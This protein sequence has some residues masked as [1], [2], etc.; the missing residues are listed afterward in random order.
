[1]IDHVLKA[2]AELEWPLVVV[3]A[4]L[5]FRRQIS[6]LIQ[7][8]S[9]VRLG[10]QEFRVSRQIEGVEVLLE[11]NFT[12][13]PQVSL[14]PG[15]IESRIRKLLEKRPEEALRQVTVELRQSVFVL[16]LQSG[17][18]KTFRDSDGD[19]WRELSAVHRAYIESSTDVAAMMFVYSEIQRE[20]T[21]VSNRSSP[22]L[23][24]K[25]VDLGLRLISQ[26]EA[27][28]RPVLVVNQTYMEVFSDEALA[29]RI[30]GI[31]CIRVQEYGSD[32]S[33][34]PESLRPARGISHIL[35]RTIVTLEF[36]TA[37]TVPRGFVR[38]R[39]TGRAIEAWPA[40]DNPRAM[41]ASRP[42]APLNP[43]GY[44]RLTPEGA[45]DPRYARIE[46]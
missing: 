9:E 37:R 35:P 16:G 6:G 43:G 13:G 11:R 17:W 20:L 1:L 21:T 4:L 30:E 8:L 41:Y 19:L 46:G 42:L 32:G 22:G 33:V 5:L 45:P 36:E 27:V 40:D 7:N 10:G 34:S 18:A 44:G 24:R 2:L 15:K 25:A 14:V 28:D 38:D 23:Y 31:Q 26:I 29:T 39:N 12:S 3:F